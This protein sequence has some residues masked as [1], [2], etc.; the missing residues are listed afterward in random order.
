MLLTIKPFLQVYQ[1]HKPY[2]H[3]YWQHPQVV[4][5]CWQLGVI[6]CLHSPGFGQLQMLQLA[7]AAPG[8]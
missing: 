1:R 5:S 8:I 3:R 4:L 7:K 6:G 2:N